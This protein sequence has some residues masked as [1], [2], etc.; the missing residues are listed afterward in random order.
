VCL[1]EALAAQ[2]QWFRISDFAANAGRD[3]HEQGLHE[4]QAPD[5]EKQTV[6]MSECPEPSSQAQ[7]TQSKVEQ[8]REKARIEV[9]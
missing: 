1:F 8:G 9:E 5:T 6:G 2:R 7:C 4:K 3:N